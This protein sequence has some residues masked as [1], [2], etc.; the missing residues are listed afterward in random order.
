MGKYVAIVMSLALIIL[1]TIAVVAMILHINHDLLT[2]I[3]G[4]IGLALGAG[5]GAL[6]SWA[7][8]RKKPR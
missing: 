2:T 7:Y 4:I 1:G 6:G 8:Y 5:G 3:V